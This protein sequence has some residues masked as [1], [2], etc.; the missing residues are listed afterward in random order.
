MQSTY[1]ATSSTGL[2]P[3]DPLL[4]LRAWP[5]ETSKNENIPFLIARINAQRGS[6]RNVTESSLAQEIE[7]AETTALG[8]EDQESPTIDTPD[9]KPST[10]NVYK[11]RGEIARAIEW[12]YSAFK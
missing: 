8:E 4:S 9:G 2:S 1:T 10:D 7:A 5:G 11:A 6:F 3:T 12:D